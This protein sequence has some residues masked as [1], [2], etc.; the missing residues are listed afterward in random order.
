MALTNNDIFNYINFEIRKDKKGQPMTRQNLSL[1]LDIKSQ[2]YFEIIYDRYEQ[3]DEMTDSLR[4]FKTT[5]AGANLDFT[6]DMIDLPADYAHKG[7]LYHKKG[8]TDIRAVEMLSD[9]LF[10]MRQ[11]AVI[12]APSTS[13]PVARLITDYIEYLPSTLDQNNFTF[14]YLR[15]PLTA[16]YDYYLDAE[17]VVQYLTQGATHTWADDQE[18]STGTVRSSGQP[19]WDSLTVELDFEEED[20]IKIAYKILQALSVTVDETGVFQYAEQIKTES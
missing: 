7:F 16:V 8:G 15:Y 12:E 18:D 10:M 6:G 17:G 3:S 4:R 5:L 13:Y 14:S 1:I 20:K 2:E 11:T 19:D 9:D